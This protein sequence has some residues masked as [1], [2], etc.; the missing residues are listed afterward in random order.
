[1]RYRGHSSLVGFFSSGERIL[2]ESHDY[3]SE[4]YSPDALQPLIALGLR[5]PAILVVE[6]ERFS[7][8]SIY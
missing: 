1:L 2:T 4:N 5:D 3:F 8:I 7:P 6:I